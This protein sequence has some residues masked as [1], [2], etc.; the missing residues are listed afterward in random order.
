MCR[1]GAQ[2]RE[3]LRSDLNGVKPKKIGRVVEHWSYR[4]YQDLE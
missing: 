2:D 1:D 4:V 3:P